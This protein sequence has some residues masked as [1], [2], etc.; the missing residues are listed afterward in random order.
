MDKFVFRARFWVSRIHDAR[1]HPNLIL[2][3]LDQNFT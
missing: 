1:I 3:S 2:N